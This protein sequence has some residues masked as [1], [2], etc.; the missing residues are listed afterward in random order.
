MNMNEGVPPAAP[1]TVGSSASAEAQK[2]RH[3]VAVDAAAATVGQTEQ[4]LRQM[5]QLTVAAAKQE[6]FRADEEEARSQRMAVQLDAVRR[7]VELDKAEQQQV[8]KMLQLTVAA[9]KE[10]KVR[11]DQEEQGKVE[12]Q[13]LAQQLAVELETARKQVEQDKELLAAAHARELSAKELE[14][15]ALQAGLSSM[16]SRMAEAEAKVGGGDPR[17]TQLAREVEAARNFRKQAEEFE[18]TAA[19]CAREVESKESELQRL[20]AD[21]N[22]TQSRLAEAEAKAAGGC[23]VIA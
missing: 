10:E 12:Q 2:K 23:C 22:S 9:A 15:Q 18:Q 11:A 19:A 20:R 21:L 14:L 5:L 16:R 6:K 8:R 3:V 1:D 4:Q 7:Q 17:S 13:A